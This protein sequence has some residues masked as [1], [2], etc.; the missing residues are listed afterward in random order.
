MHRRRTFQLNL[1]PEGHW[2]MRNLTWMPV[3][4]AAA[5]L[6]R[7]VLADDDAFAMNQRLGRG[8]NLGNM[9]EAPTEGAWG[10][11]FNDDFLPIIRQAGFQSLRLP[12]RWSAH[13]DERPPYTIDEAFFDRVEHIVSLAL[14]ADLNVVLN[15]HHFEEIFAQPEESQARLAGMWRQIA[16]RFRDRPSRLYFEVLNE[17]HDKLTA[18]IWNEMVPELLAVI[19]ESNPDRMVIIGPGGWNA[20]ASLPTLRLPEDDRRIIVTFHYY[21]PF[22]FTH[23]GAAWVGTPHPV[24]RKWTATPAEQADI[25]KDFDAAAAWSRE[26]NRP[27]Y[28]GEFGAYSRADMESRV[29]WTRFIRDEAEERKF[30]WSYWEFA[31]G[32]GV[33][34]PQARGWRSPLRDALVAE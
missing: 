34:D 31:A 18:E 20:L 17:P 33:W 32:F 11:R 23:Q 4:L 19:R 28:L 6:G 27:L 2:I 26:H 21:L 16:R 22:P 10:V 12:I 3:L 15:V 5:C 24:G 14:Q 7:V 13:A 8:V 30:S 25:R 29:R 1:G 9:L